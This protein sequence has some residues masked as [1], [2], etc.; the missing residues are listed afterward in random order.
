MIYP[1]HTYRKKFRHYGAPTTV[2]KTNPWLVASIIM[3]LPLLM[4]LA[5]LIFR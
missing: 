3:S 1:A 5:V 2:V 4:I